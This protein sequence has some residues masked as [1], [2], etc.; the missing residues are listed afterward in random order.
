VSL[1][2][3]RIIETIVSTALGL[4]CLILGTGLVANGVDEAGYM[5]LGGGLGIVGKYA[6]DHHWNT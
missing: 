3:Q 1:I 4:A 2:T 6:S 5:L